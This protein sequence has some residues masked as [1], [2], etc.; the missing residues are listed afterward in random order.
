MNQKHFAVNKI[1]CSDSLWSLVLS[2]KRNF[3]YK[4]AKVAARVLRTTI[5]VWTDPESPLEKRQEA[6]KRFNT[7]GIRK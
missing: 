3:G 2:G 7:N 4:H 6:W 1:G 5:S